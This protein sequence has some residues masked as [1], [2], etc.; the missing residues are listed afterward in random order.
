MNEQEV[1]ALLDSTEI[2]YDPAHPDYIEAAKLEELPLPFMEWALEE[3]SF[4]AD[5]VCYATW[6]R[7]TVRVFTDTATKS[8]ASTVGRAL[9]RAGLAYQPPETEF[10]P[11]LGIWQTT[12]TTEV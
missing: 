12:F 7:L 3:V 10:L 4:Y 8:A 2:Y 6:E 11:E 5:D 9:R 1:Q